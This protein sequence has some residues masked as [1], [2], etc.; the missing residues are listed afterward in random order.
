MIGLL[1]L[2][3][4]ILLL[5]L[6]HWWDIT[7]DY[8]V[9]IDLAKNHS[10]YDTF[11]ALSHIA[12]AAGWDDA[13]EYYAYPPAPLYIY[14][15]LAK[16]YYLL[17]PHANYFFV[18]SGSYAV[19][20][21]TID[22]FFLLKAP[23]WI[24]DFLIAALL[25][26]M[27]GTVR[28]A[29]DYLLNPYVLMVSGAWTFDAIMVLGLVA[30]IY[31]IL[32]GRMIW[33]GV[34]L[35]FGTMVKFFPAIAVPTVVIYLIK[36]KRPLHEIVIFLVAYSVACLAFLGPFF[37][38]F[39]TV[40][41]F[42]GTRSGGGMTW[43]YYWTA[44]DLFSNTDGVRVTLDTLSTFGTP[45]LVIAMLLTYWY[46]LKTEMTLNRMMVVTLLGFF[47]GSKLI[48]EQYVLMIIPFLWLEA[49]RL[50]GAWRWFYRLFWIVPLVF[51]L[52]HVP[53]DRFFW[54]FYHMILKDKADF[55]V[56]GVT[57]FEWSL[58]P[59]KHQLES[60]RIVLVLAI[61]F[62]TLAVVALLWPVRWPARIPRSSQ[63][64]DSA[65]PQDAFDKSDADAESLSVHREDPLSSQQTTG[66]SS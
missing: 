1:A 31:F 54:L 23:I 8:N 17:H 63:Q 7:I 41:N 33:A 15:P 60:E 40:L 43:M 48:N 30:G 44:T 56:T 34:A 38:G 2:F 10:P 9:F 4:R 57:G 3:L 29:R 61:S 58:F 11:T 53:L 49:Y 59:W 42:H 37:S 46:I 35:A 18:V 25:A 66:A 6:G 27:S 28:S 21:L 22:F 5:P 52:F 51:A 55:T 13:Y 62:F 45:I 19:P 36:K 32:R 14:Y 12:R 26:R 65:A 47:V 64:P 24:A 39:L 50:G 16:I 20:N